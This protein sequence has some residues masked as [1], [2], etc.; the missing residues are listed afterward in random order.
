VRGPPISLL[1]IGFG[2]RDGLEIELLE[3][4]ADAVGAPG[5]EFGAGETVWARWRGNRLGGFLSQR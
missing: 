2:A 3:G 1:E 5:F 4:E